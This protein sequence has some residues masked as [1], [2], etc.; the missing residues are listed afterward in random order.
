MEQI[1]VVFRTTLCSLMLPKNLNMKVLCSQLP[2]INFKLRSILLRPTPSI[3]KLQLEEERNLML[4]VL[5]L[6]FAKCHYSS[7]LTMLVSITSM[8]EIQETPIITKSFLM[9]HGKKRL[10]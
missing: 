7:S 10:L 8:I 6:Q 9:T 2:L 3:C 5:L 4:R 1:N